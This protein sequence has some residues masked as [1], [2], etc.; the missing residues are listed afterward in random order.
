MDQH[1][2]LMALRKQEAYLGQQQADIERLRSFAE[3]GRDS[4]WGKEQ[5]P[6][7]ANAG[8]LIC[9]TLPLPLYHGSDM[10]GIELFFCLAHFSASAQ[11]S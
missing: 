3:V 6:E 10:T 1:Y 4:E 8:F 11:L 7:G 9:Q 2:C 5:N